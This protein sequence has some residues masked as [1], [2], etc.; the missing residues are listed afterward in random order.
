VEN[1]LASPI[2]VAL[3]EFG[4]SRIIG[5]VLCRNVVITTVAR[6]LVACNNP[7]YEDFAPGRCS[8]CLARIC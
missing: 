3:K 2:R 1:R 5:H 7:N 6:P 8:T 4:Q